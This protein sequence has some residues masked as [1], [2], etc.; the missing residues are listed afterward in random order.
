[1]VL[2]CIFEWTN[3]RNKDEYFFLAGSK[4]VALIIRCSVASATAASTRSNSAYA[5]HAAIMASVAKDAEE[6]KQTLLIAHTGERLRQI[7]DWTLTSIDDDVSSF[8][9]KLT[10]M[11]MDLFLAGSA[12]SN[13][14]ASW[15]IYGSRRIIVSKAALRERLARKRASM[16]A[17]PEMSRVGRARMVSPDH[18]VPIGGLSSTKRS[19][20]L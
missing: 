9:K 6:V 4:V 15:K 11:E 2:F 18:L 19:R 8:T 7:F 12:A 17:T 13:A 3:E 10:E 14:A 16:T 20:T 1:M 5:Q